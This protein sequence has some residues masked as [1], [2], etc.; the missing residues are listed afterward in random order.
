MI[1]HK[2][3]EGGLSI[4]ISL[5]FIAIGAV[6][7]IAGFKPVLEYNVGSIIAPIIFSLLFQL[8]SN[9][10]FKSPVFSILVGL[11]ILS[12]FIL[13]AVG[14]DYKIFVIGAIADILLYIGEWLD[15]TRNMPGTIGVY[16]FLFL[17]VSVVVSIVL[18]SV[19]VV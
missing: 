17:F 13:I 1:M 16:T 4:F 14:W 11:F 18:V 3:A 7:V 12:S 8:I 9:F 6:W 10:D 2:K 19:F 5:M 15:D